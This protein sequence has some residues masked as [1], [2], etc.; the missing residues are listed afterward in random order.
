MKLLIRLRLSENLL[1][2]TLEESDLVQ[3]Q[4]EFAAC[5]VPDDQIRVFDL[6]RQGHNVLGLVPSRPE[7]VDQ[8][9][10]IGC[11]GPFDEIHWNGRSG[12]QNFVNL[13]E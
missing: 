4:L 9:Y 3:D 8:L 13:N 12:H 11:R 7:G 10:S 6:I 1:G 5:R 2:L